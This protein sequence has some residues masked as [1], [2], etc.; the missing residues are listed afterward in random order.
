MADGSEGRLLSQLLTA[1][2]R[3]LGYSLL[4]GL[5]SYLWVRYEV[6]PEFWA[7]GIIFPIVLGRTH[8]GISWFRGGLYLANSMGV[9]WVAIQIATA[10]NEHV[11]G[12]F[13]AAAMALVIALLTRTRPTLIGL[14]APVVASCA[15][16][17]L[18]TLLPGSKDGPSVIFLWQLFVGVA[19]LAGRPAAT[20]SAS[21]TPPLPQP[22]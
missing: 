13:G 20:A 5:L 7:P 15:A 6:P 19:L 8:V 1:Y 2:G 16:T 9:W 4:A 3:P 12:I 22:Q 21:Q 18:S 17:G 11:A 10:Q 14:L